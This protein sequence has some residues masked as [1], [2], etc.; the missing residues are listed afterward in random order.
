MRAQAPWLC[1][2]ADFSMALLWHN[3]DTLQTAHMLAQHLLDRWQATS[4]LYR[5][6]G[7]VITDWE[8]HGID[9]MPRPPARPWYP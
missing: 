8:A 5:A 2:R 7:A 3:G 4:P 1:S 6:A 9:L